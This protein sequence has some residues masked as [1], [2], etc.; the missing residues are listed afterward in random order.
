[1]GNSNSPIPSGNQIV[2]KLLLEQNLQRKLEKFVLVLPPQV[3]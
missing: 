3:L 1:M 2:L